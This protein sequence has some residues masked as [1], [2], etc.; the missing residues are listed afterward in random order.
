MG[1][2]WGWQT[3]SRLPRVQRLCNHHQP[4]VLVSWLPLICH[5]FLSK[6]TLKNDKNKMEP[7]HIWISWFLESGLWPD[8]LCIYLTQILVL[9]DSNLVR[10]R[11]NKWLKFAKETLFTMYTLMFK[12]FWS[13]TLHTCGKLKVN[14]NHKE[15]CELTLNSKDAYTST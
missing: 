8:S 14:Q 4:H 6:V 13:W 15:Y 7:C 10:V 1:I 12:Q 9:S 2:S 3:G 5:A 11:F